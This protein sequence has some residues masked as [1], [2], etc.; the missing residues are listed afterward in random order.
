MY[1]HHSHLA[2]AGQVQVKPELANS[3]SG[4]P[5]L[6]ACAIQLV[7]PIRQLAKLND[8]VYRP[9]DSLMILLACQICS[10]LPQLAGSIQGHC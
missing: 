8:L 2:P 6:C 3:P 5:S 10:Q 7:K 1:A 4:Q 9:L